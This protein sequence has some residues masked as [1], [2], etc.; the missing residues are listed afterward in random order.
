MKRIFLFSLILLLFA[1][2]IPLVFGAGAAKPSAPDESPV[3]DA[4]DGGSLTDGYLLSGV[5]DG[6]YRFTAKV[7]G[8]VAEYTMAEYLPCVLAGEMPAL[9]EADAL[10]AQAVAARTYIM[11]S[12]GRTNPNHPDAAVC[13][14]P[15]CCKAHSGVEAMR[16][17]WGDKFDEYYQKLRA[18]VFE[19]D[20]EYLVYENEPI[21]AAFHS[22]SA[23]MTESSG[24]VWG[25]VPYLVSVDSPETAGDVPNYNSV[26]E[27]SPDE[28][29][30]VILAEYPDADFSGEPESWL[31][32]ISKNDSGRT[33]AV[34]I[35]GAEIT[36]TRMRT[37]FSLRSAAFEISYADGRFVFSVT[38]YGHGVGMSQFGANVMAKQGADYKDILSHY[39][40]GTELI[41]TTANRT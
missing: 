18:A 23:G 3:A 28:L 25:D 1:I 41:Q 7:G 38:G 13:D 24:A 11:Y 37:L 20:G 4:S 5:S 21:L 31:G 16:E 40:P 29:K 30:S 22:S 14:D 15:T 36:G 8:D 35:G 19:T 27:V 6:E 17:S 32:G 9:F 10:K 34:V 39:Y 33:A 26:V 12:V 2:F